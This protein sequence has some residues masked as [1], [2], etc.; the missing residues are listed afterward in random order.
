MPT[1]YKPDA[2]VIALLPI[3]KRLYIIY[4][5]L[6]VLLGVLNSMD[7]L[8]FDG[9]W[10][11]WLIIWSIW[12]LLGTYLNWRFKR[13]HKQMQRIVEFCNSYT[14]INFKADQLLDVTNKVYM[15]SVAENVISEND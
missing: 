10:I 5:L 11:R 8:I 4:S 6:A 3:E 9:V 15:Q 13:H 2:L 1:E 14:G 7:A 12:W